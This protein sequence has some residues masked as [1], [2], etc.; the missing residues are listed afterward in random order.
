MSGLRIAAPALR[1][2]ATLTVAAALA[3]TVG[4][5]CRR[6][7]SCI[8]CYERQAQGPLDQ[9]G[10]F[11]VLAPQD[12]PLHQPVSSPDADLSVQPLTHDEPIESLP[13]PAGVETG[14]ETPENAGRR[15]HVPPDLPGAEAGPVVLPPYAGP[16]DV[17]YKAALEQLYGGAPD[18]PGSPPGPPAGDEPLDLAQLQALALAHSPV[19]RVAAARI[20]QARGLALQAG[21]YPN[22]AVGYQA[23]TVNTS[24]TAGYH[25]AYVQQTFITAGKLK[26]ARSAAE[27]DL[28][29]ARLELRKARIDVATAV[30]AAYFEALVAREKVRIQSTLADFTEEIFRTQARLV[31]GGEAAAYEPLEL[32]VF[33][34]Q[35]RAAVVQARQSDGAAQRKLAAALGLPELPVGRLLGR[36]DMPIPAIDYDA[37]RAV[38]LAR[39]TELTAS[40]NSVV[41]AQRLLQLALVAPR[42]D[43]DATLA[44][45]H[46]D[47][48][49]PGATT[50]N[51]Q[52]GGPIPVF[53]RNT[54]NII[55]AQA[56]V[57]ETQHAVSRVENALTARLADAYGRYESN[58][59]LAQDFQPAALRDQ[60]RTYRGIYE[61]YHRGS[62]GVAFGEVIVAQQLLSTLLA[63]YLDLL[64][65]QWQAVV[66]VAELLQVDDVYLLGEAVPVTPLPDLPA[67][68]K[69]AFQEPPRTSG[70]SRQRA[71]NPTDSSPR[72]S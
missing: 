4:C 47:T 22:P 5:R 59:R 43:L 6:E 63:Q 60:V 72:P 71:G 24:N 54:G 45:Q 13:A 58:R 69:G 2:G 57:A 50:V 16:D 29:N 14:S 55:A 7:P 42:P 19:V 32:R 65:Q 20:E 27:V 11:P 41:Q 31:E 66:D 49:D 10:A 51:V 21:A 36:P 25:G 70:S 53:N 61:R 30:R 28:L 44:V 12:L 40:R 17:P 34:L 8:P 46:D 48:F 56:K 52:V 62:E 15:L 33:L 23:D 64:G 18:V 35:A 38:M 1:I 39:H 3:A 26:L 9:T 37:A 67:A 68:P